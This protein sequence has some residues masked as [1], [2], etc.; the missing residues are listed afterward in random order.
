MLCIV[1]HVSMVSLSSGRAMC[2][3]VYY[4]HLYYRLM[5]RNTS[6]PTILM[7]TERLKLMSLHRY[8]MCI[9][10][11][12]IREGKRERG[13]ERE[14]EREREKGRGE[15]ERCTHREVSYRKRM[16]FVYIDSTPASYGLMISQ[17]PEPTLVQMATSSHRLC[18]LCWKK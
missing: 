18:P 1:V 3:C 7:A 5:D 14:G 8:N 10:C 12:C 13:G 4:V 11:V 17:S 15:G 6:M 16:F 9:I 2:V